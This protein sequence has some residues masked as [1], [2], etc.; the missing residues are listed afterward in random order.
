MMNSPID[1]R[2]FSMDEIPDRMHRL[3]PIQR[4]VFERI[5]N[6]LLTSGAPFP[7]RA[8]QIIIGKQDAIADVFKGL[9]GGLLIEN[10]ENDDTCFSLT[11][12]GALLTPNGP[13]LATLL[14]RL[15]E[16]LKKTYEEDPLV[17]ILDSRAIR[18]GLQLSE[19]ESTQLLCLL[20]LG[21]PPGMP[22]SLSGWK[23]VDPDS[24][25]IT[26]RREILDLYRCGD[27][28][29]YLNARLSA[30][31]DP[32][33]PYESEARTKRS[34]ARTFAAQEMVGA[35]QGEPEAKQMKIFISWSGDVSHRVAL[36]LRKWISVVLPF[37]DPWVSSE[38]IGKGSRWGQELADQLQETNCGIICLTP[39][40]A[41]EPWLN[42][43]AGALSK[44]VARAQVHPFLTGMR[45]AELE[46]PLAQ[47]Q[48]TEFTQ[49]DMR[50]LIG[51]INA[52]AAEKAMQPH[53]IENSFQLLWPGLEQAMKPLAAEAR[54]EH[55][56]GN[57]NQVEMSAAAAPVAADDLSPEETTVL[58]LM[59]DAPEAIPAKYL[60]GALNV[61]PQRAEHILERL[62]ERQLVFFLDNYVSGRTWRLSAEGRAELVR[63][64][65]L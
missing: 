20:R 32:D 41:R 59:A 5:W 56:A 52:A 51:A 57:V 16:W 46:G 10:L 40:N 38:N 63:R 44:T 15:L 36:E 26:I 27:V 48:A 65:L 35:S 12:Y 53:K 1:A 7:A 11:I 60:A 14:F 9:D 24:W 47:F 28:L 34:L 64:N 4:T 17:K 8:L 39:E 31:Y 43:E 13:V 3:S 54:G 49:S 61:H 58:R 19:S 22:F 2:R 21:L 25:T 18:A 30:G 29:E 37:T 62:E 55:L 50:K 23:G 45:P 42:F 33:E 6:Y